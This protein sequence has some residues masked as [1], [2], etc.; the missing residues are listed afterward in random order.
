MTRQL[1]Q[2]PAGLAANLGVRRSAFESVGGFDEDLRVGED[3]DLCW[4]LQFAGYRF[5]AVPEAVVAKRERETARRG[6][7]RTGSPMVEVGRASTA[8][9]GAAGIRRDFWAPPSPGA[10][11][12]V[13]IPWLYRRD[14]RRR[15]LRVA[16][17]PA[18][19]DS[20]IAGEPGVLPL[21]GAVVSGQM[22]ARHAPSATYL[23]G[24]VAAHRD[25]RRFG[26][27]RDPERSCEEAVGSPEHPGFQASTRS[28]GPRTG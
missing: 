2:V 19:E 8:S 5:A 22:A 14:L 24:I 16:G 3:I 15:W 7:S 4:R 28:P 18:G 25:E 20:R 1:G 26:R 13:E 11:L 21:S 23:S 17:C 10:W 27:P 6:V 12:V 9:T